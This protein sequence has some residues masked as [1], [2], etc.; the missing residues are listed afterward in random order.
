[1]DVLELAA[2]QVVHHAYGSPPLDQTVTIGNSVTWR[3]T[4]IGTPPPTYQWLKDGVA[5][6]G[7]TTPT[8]TLGTTTAAD[9]G[10]YTLTA[11]NAAGAARRPFSP[12]AF[13]SI[14]SHVA[15]RRG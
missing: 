6:P 14:T 11:T 7:A 13:S 12:C 8:L 2:A 1:L 4:A 9:A 3:A 15:S 5:L 10:R